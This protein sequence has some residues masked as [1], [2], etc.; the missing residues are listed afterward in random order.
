MAFASCTVEPNGP[1]CALAPAHCADYAAWA[2]CASPDALLTCNDHCDSMPTSLCHCSKYV[3][4]IGRD[5]DPN[6][7]AKCNSVPSECQQA[8]LDYQVCLPLGKPWRPGGQC[9]EQTTCPSYCCG[10]EFYA[11]CVTNPNGAGC[12]SAPAVC[13]NAE[14][15]IACMWKV[16]EVV[17]PTCGIQ[18]CTMV[19][20]MCQECLSYFPCV[21]GYLANMYEPACQPGNFPAHCLQCVPWVG[22][23]QNSVSSMA[24]AQPPPQ[25]G[26]SMMPVIIGGAA[27]AV[28]VLVLVIVAYMKLNNRTP[29]TAPKPP[30][31]RP[32]A[33]AM[34]PGIPTVPMQQGSPPPVPLVQPQ[35]AQPQFA[36][37]Q[38]VQSQVV[39]PQIM[40]TSP[41]QAPPQTRG[42]RFDPETGAPLPK[43]DPAT[44][45]QNWFDDVPQGNRFDPNT[46][47]ELPK[48][49]PNT[50]KQNWW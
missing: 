27:G 14:C 30:P 8:A 37:A 44:G 15:D 48:F 18:N 28:F 26:G 21:A 47:K 42:S 11:H 41:P 45:K 33:S 17:A 31:S 1:H 7:P 9:Y 35:F 29:K 19:P 10:C 25:E 6:R 20:D 50:G 24:W 5:Y 16:D 2:R 36:Q 3:D 4:C 38:M 13:A 40:A 32:T 34:Q 46:G 23:T 12:S 49:D 39:Q 43:F 22:C